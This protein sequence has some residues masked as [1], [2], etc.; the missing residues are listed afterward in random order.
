[1][2]GATLTFW[3]EE[4][5]VEKCAFDIPKED[6]EKVKNMTEEEVIEYFYS[7]EGT[8]PTNEYFDTVRLGKEEVIS[9][10]VPFDLN[11]EVWDD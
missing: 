7:K 3:R 1:M 5:S 6:V 10:D 4:R 11:L 9:A 2:K 8:D